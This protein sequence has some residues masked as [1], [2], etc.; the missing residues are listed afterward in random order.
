MLCLIVSND[1]NNS[2]MGSFYTTMRPF[3]WYLNTRGGRKSFEGFQF[4]KLVVYY[5]LLFYSCWKIACQETQLL[6]FLFTKNFDFILRE[7]KHHK[8]HLKFSIFVGQC[9]ISLWWAQSFTL[10]FPKNSFKT[11]PECIQSFLYL[12]DP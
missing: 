11:P 5:I 1:T 7:C 3:L 6:F 12:L 10:Q 2:H 9:S 4:T 8:M